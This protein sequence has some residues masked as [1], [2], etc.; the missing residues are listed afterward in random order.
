L[1][2]KVYPNPVTYGKVSIE[3]GDLNPG[4]K[5]Y[6][7][8]QSGNLAAAYEATAGKTTINVEHLPGGSYFL[9]AGI[10]VVKLIVIK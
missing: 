8:N 3:T 6:I 1:K 7:Y 2:V 4:E 10:T 5:I 9:K